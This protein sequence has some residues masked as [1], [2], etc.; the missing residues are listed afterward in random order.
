MSSNEEWEIHY[1][2]LKQKHPTAIVI[3]ANLIK[4]YLGYTHQSIVASAKSCIHELLFCNSKRPKT[5][6]PFLKIV[7]GYLC[8]VICTLHLERFGKAKHLTFYIR[9]LFT[10]HTVFE[11]PSLMPFLRIAFIQC[12]PKTC[13]A[14]AP[15]FYKFKLNLYLYT[16]LLC[17]TAVEIIGKS[18]VHC[19]YL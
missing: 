15:S 11:D 18:F 2:L 19:I 3:H 4:E 12:R 7:W 16:T 13:V 17:E 1:R 9:F 6:D 5:A 10:D 14:Y 8:Y